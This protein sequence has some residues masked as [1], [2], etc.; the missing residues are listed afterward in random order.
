MSLKSWKKHFGSLTILVLLA[1]L[2]VAATAHAEYIITTVA[3][4]GS[5]GLGDGGPATSAQLNFPRAIAFDSNDNLYIADQMNHRIRKVDTSGNIST[6]AGSGAADYGLGD[7]SGDG[8]AATSAKLNN[9]LGVA[10]DSRGNLYIADSYNQRIRKVD[11]FGKISTIAGSASIISDCGWEDGRCAKLRGGFSGDGG[12]AVNAELNIPH[13]IAIDI[14]DNLYIADWANVRIRKVD[15]SGKIYTVAGGGSGGLGDGDLATS[16]E[17]NYPRS[18]AVDNSG[19][20]YIADTFN[21]RIRKVN[22]SDG[23]IS[24]V[25]GNGTQGFSGDGGPATSAQLTN[26][27][28]VAFD[29][30]GNLYITDE[31]NRIRKVNVSSG[32]ISTVV[33]NGIRGFNGDGGPA[34]SAQLNA[35]IYVAFDSNGNLYIADSLNHRIRKVS[36]SDCIDTNGSTQQGIDMVKANPGSYQLFTQSQ[37]EQKIADAVSA[38]TATMYTKA[39]LDE[40]VKAEQLKWDANG[41]GR[42]GLEDIIRMLQVLAGLRP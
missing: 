23:K 11:T 22:I 42:I 5:N 27:M 6:V 37:V 36:K 13:H 4:G 29:S 32:I 8:G 1:W 16:A 28:G 24:T 35:T 7:F 10:F 31:S 9:P 14:W 40:A 17:F 18:V 20:F 33:G 41:D 34:T 12:Q 15:T 25:A 3:G 21:Q 26:P 38:A 19:N 39:Q 30:N 2:G